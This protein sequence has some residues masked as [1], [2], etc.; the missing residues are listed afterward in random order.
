MR[1]E[2]PATKIPDTEILGAT[3]RWDAIWV[4]MWPDNLICLDKGQGL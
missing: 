2:N 4:L 1:K 3:T